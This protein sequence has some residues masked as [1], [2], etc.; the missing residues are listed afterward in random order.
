MIDPEQLRLFILDAV[1]H[2]ISAT[3]PRV[4]RTEDDWVL[5]F[6]IHLVKNAWFGI[7]AV[8][9]TRHGRTK[10]DLACGPSKS[11]RAEGLFTIDRP[12]LD[13]SFRAYDAAYIYTAVPVLV[14]TAAEDHYKIEREKGAA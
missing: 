2:Y 1:P 10:L 7:T 6:N 13:M 4:G 9:K 12:N 5:G 14:G 11:L 3:M 8:S